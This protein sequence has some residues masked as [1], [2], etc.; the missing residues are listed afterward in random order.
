M[1]QYKDKCGYRKIGACKFKSDQCNS[2]DC[3]MYN[4]EFSSKAIREKMK[5]LKKEIKEYSK[6][7]FKKT[8]RV[9]ELE[10]E[11]RNHPEVVE[12]KRKLLRLQDL[13][14]GYQI[15]Q[16]AYIYCKRIGK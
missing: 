14:A 13:D 6:I 7:G 4:I 3:D 15:M 11:D 16:K 10:K 9:I 8:Q 2:T 1:A 5:E 12:F